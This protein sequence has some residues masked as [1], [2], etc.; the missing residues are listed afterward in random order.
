ME[1]IIR[2]ALFGLKAILM[3]VG[4]I[5]IYRT[6]STF[7]SDWEVSYKTDQFFNMD[8]FDS[9]MSSLGGTIGFSMILIYG[10]I[11]LIVLFGIWGMVT[12]FK[13]AR[14]FLI[15]LVFLVIVG[16]IAYYAMSSGEID[17]DWET[18]EVITAETSKWSEAGIKAVF[19]LII[20][21]LTGIVVGEVSKIFK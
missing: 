12:N 14:T 11:A 9:F 7:N 2:P 19:I 8:I 16:A 10:T 20:L 6:V 1:K 4:V 18:K 5:L 3:I 21:S 13:K 17:P 15:G